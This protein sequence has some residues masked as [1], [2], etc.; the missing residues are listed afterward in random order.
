MVMLLEELGVISADPVNPAA[1][2]VSAPAV[3]PA[4]LLTVPIFRGL[5]LTKVRDEVPMLAPTVERLFEVL[6]RL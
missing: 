1:V 3:I 5:P 6:D 2:K 4:I